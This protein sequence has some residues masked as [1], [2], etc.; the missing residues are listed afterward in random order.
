MTDV[1]RDPDADAPGHDALVVAEYVGLR[2]EII[3]LIELQSQL[4]SL[5]VVTVGAVLG[6]AVQTQSSGLAFVY[7][8]PALILG[9]TWLNHAHAISRCALYLSQD[10]EPHRGNGALGWEGFV[11]RNPLRF[12]M[13]GYWGVRSVFMGSSLVALVVGWSLI[14]GHALLIIAGVIST[15]ISLGTVALFLL[16]RESSPRKLL[17]EDLTSD[18]V[19]GE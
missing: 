11:R 10:F 17:A 1:D 16:W 9:I 15:L 5:A 13:L 19:L 3:K 18:A 8:V 12:G 2:S 6:V 14:R 7:P 4:V